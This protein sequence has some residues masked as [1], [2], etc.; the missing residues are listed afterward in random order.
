M[1]V[2]PLRHPLMARF[3]RAPAPGAP[4]RA[5]AQGTRCRLLAGHQGLI[6]P[7]KGVK[8]RTMPAKAK[9]ALTP[10]I[11]QAR[12]QVHQLL[13]HRADAPTLRLMAHRGVR[14]DEAGKPDVA[15]DV[16]DERCH[17]K[18]EI[19]GRKLP[20]GQPLDVEIGLEFGVELLARR[21]L[22]IQPDDLGIGELQRSPPALDVHLGNPQRLALSIDGALGDPLS[23][24][25]KV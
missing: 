18:H 13:H 17:R 4:A 2:A 22:F 12:G 3:G 9:I 25:R 23:T 7:T 20:R 10:V 16:V 24:R 8:P 1:L 5:Y 21:M 19:V 15:Q 14:A 11:D 6:D